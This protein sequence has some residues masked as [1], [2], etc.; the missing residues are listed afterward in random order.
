MTRLRSEILQQKY[1]ISGMPLRSFAVSYMA[2]VEQLGHIVWPFYNLFASWKF[3][4]NIIK[5]II[6]F[7]TERDIPTLSRVTMR[8]AVQRECRKHQGTVTKGKVF[9]F[10]DEFT[11]FQEA[12]LGLTFAKLLLRLGYEVEI[13]KH[14]ESGRA[15]ITHSSVLAWRIPRTV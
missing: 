15:A 11:N 10:A 5:R 4:S 7:T 6:N 8:K 2:T 12:E 3:S 13:P 14:V 1:D 9:L